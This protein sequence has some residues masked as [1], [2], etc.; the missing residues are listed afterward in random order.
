M[1]IRTISLLVIPVVAAVSG[2]SSSEKAAVNGFIASMERQS[3]EVS[4][5]EEATFK[6]NTEGTDLQISWNKGELRNTTRTFVLDTSDPPIYGYELSAL[7]EQGYIVAVAGDDALFA[8]GEVVP[9][10]SSYT[11]FGAAHFGTQPTN[12]PTT[13][14]VAYTGA[15]VGVLFPASG[16]ADTYIGDT[17]IDVDFGSGGVTG[18]L[19]NIQSINNGAVPNIG[20][21]G[22][23]E[24][25]KSTYTATN[26]TWNNVAA[27][28]K[29]LGGLYGPGATSTAGAF[30]ISNTGGTMRTIGGYVAVADFQ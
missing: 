10:S 4:E 21:S 20:F 14:T 27:N 24:A 30:D 29:V 8:V 12:V 23:L 15:T 28:G 6:Y 26:V 11:T 17:S 18:S 22:N 2:C 3:G 7:D 25:G 19:T 16:A 1:N 9:V 5:S 13:G